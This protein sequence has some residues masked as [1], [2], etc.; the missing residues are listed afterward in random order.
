M[1]GSENESKGL[2]KPILVFFGFLGLTAVIVGLLKLVQK[3]KNEK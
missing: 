2:A 1:P 3:G